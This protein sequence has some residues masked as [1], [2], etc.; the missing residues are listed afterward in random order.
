[1]FVLPRSNPAYFSFVIHLLLVAI[2]DAI[3]IYLFPVIQCANWISVSGNKS[4]KKCVG[5]RKLTRNE[6]M[7]SNSSVTSEAAVG[8]HPL[9]LADTGIFCSS[10]AG[11]SH[12]C[13]H[14]LCRTCFFYYGVNNSY[15]TKQRYTQNI[16][17]LN[18]LM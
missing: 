3:F 10:L 12:H 18:Y 13:L 15:E 8:S 17:K 5:G 14:F 7:F 2:F 4:D 16:V 11:P 9:P 6:R 1:M